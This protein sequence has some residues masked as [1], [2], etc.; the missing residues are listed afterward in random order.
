MDQTPLPRPKVASPP[1]TTKG[2]RSSEAFRRAAAD[3]FA[4]KGFLNATVADIA[5]AAKRSPAA[6]Y[7]HYESKEDVLIALFRDFSDA[8][9]ERA[10]QMFDP[11]AEP[12]AQIDQLVGNFVT[13]YQEW[14]PVLTAVFQQSM[15]DETFYGHW[16]A[17]RQAAVTSIRS[18]VTNAQ[19]KGSGRDLDANLAASA[20]AAMLDGFCY[21]WLARE[22]DLDDVDFDMKSAQ[23]TLSALV[24]RSLYSG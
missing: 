21:V 1:A 16:K 7:Y 20:L 11:K 17:I 2:R 24:Y 23:H 19:R 3:V 13:I 18:W 14:L 15:V 6:F 9:M 8:V 22:G 12:E 4:D 5:A 10:N